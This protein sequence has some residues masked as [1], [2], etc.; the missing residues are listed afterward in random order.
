METTKKIILEGLERHDLS[1][2]PGR[3]PYDCSFELLAS[4]PARKRLIMV[5]FNGSSADGGFTNAEAVINGF[6]SPCF[7]NVQAGTEGEWGI[8]HLANRL[9]SV[10]EQLGFRWQD[11]V[12]TN[13]LLMCSKDAL[14]LKK[15][16]QECAIGS[17]DRLI[18]KSMGFFENVTVPLCKPE[19]I[20]AYSNGMNSHSAA[21]LLLKTFGDVDEPE[22]ISRNSYYST[23][24]FTAR[25]KQFDVPVV[26]IRHMSRFKPDVQLIKQAWEKMR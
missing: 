25:F 12:Y 1:E 16:A 24:G 2:L 22:Y 4:K 21:R 19:L 14:S 26:G 11:T 9:Q 17:L 7:S 6:N 13:A 15:S 10:P 20:I 3:R 5:G 23:F 8:K 18:E